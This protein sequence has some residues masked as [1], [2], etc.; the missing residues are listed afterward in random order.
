MHRGNCSHILRSFRGN[1]WVGKGQRGQP[2]CEGPTPRAGCTRGSTAPAL[3]SMGRLC[4]W[5]K[6]RG[7]VQAA[8][9]MADQHPPASTSRQPPFQI[10]WSFLPLPRGTEAPVTGASDL[11]LHSA[12][13]HL[14]FRRLLAR[15]LALQAG[16]GH[17][18]VQERTTAPHPFHS[19]SAHT[20][21]L[22]SL[23]VSTIR[24]RGG[25]T[26]AYLSLVKTLYRPAVLQG[27]GS[28]G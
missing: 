11:N 16:M 14:A 5:V 1:L 20:P 19:R 6:L 26:S 15:A 25:W 23:L 4:M 21:P 27:V 9:G 2:R 13:P 8:S 28:A 7:L 22:R 3:A 18:G 24:K 12:L 10:C 17:L